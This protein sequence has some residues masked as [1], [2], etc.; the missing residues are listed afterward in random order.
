[1]K[2]HKRP[3]INTEWLNRG[4]ESSVKTCLPLFYKE[5]VGCMHW[6]LVNGKT[7]THLSWGWRPGDGEP[8]VWQHDLYTN[9]HSVYDENEIELFRK[10]IGLSKKKALMTLR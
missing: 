10:Y 9:D 3:I 6:G 8:E 2:Q 4:R 1:L 5:N 7:Q